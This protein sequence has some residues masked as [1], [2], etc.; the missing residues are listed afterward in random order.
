M[1]RRLLATAFAGL[2]IGAAMLP[3]AAT[4]AP[5]PHLRE[6]HLQD[7]AEAWYATAPIVGC[8]LP[9]IGCLPRF[10][11]D[12]PPYPS[13]TL[14][15]AAVLGRETAR[16]YLG[17]DETAVRG[18]LHHA[19]MTL[20]VD[21]APLAETTLPATAAIE[22]CAATGLITDGT[23]GSTTTP[24][25]TDCSPHTTAR[26]DAKAN[27]FTI[28]LTHLLNR[29]GHRL[30]GI[31]LIPAPKQAPL[32]TWHV[33]F[34]DRITP[35]KHIVLTALVVSAHLALPRPAPTRVPAGSS[36]P[37]TSQPGPS[38]TAPSEPVTSPGAIPPAP[39]P[40]IAPT[41]RAV[42]DTRP[43]GFQY[44]QVLLLPLTL[45]AGAVF[46]ARLLTE[47]AKPLGKRI[48]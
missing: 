43:S 28:D 26:Y 18:G 45:I 6:V 5:R 13:D 25:H 23:A 14:H 48:P 38:V 32:A 41:Q 1:R 27:A 33:A 7:T 10:L 42:A 34:A 47:E 24:P 8:S 17:L 12:L 29:D 44:P 36:L 11:V 2:A 30:T 15:V 21:T 22:V 35:G 3:A 39:P 16:T 20:P 37:S 9:I 40:T 19:V 4:G 46:L 31:A